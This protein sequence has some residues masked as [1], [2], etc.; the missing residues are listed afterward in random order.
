[1]QLR[2]GGHGSHRTGRTYTDTVWVAL[3]DDESSA[4][5]QARAVVADT[6]SVPS[7]RPGPTFGM[8]SRCVIAASAW[9]PVSR[10]R[11]QRC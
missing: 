6:V 5:D 9:P 8:W 2:Y 4:R 10:A 1:M 7:R 11:R 3:A